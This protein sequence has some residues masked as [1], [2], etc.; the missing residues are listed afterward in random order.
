MHFSQKVGNERTDHAWDPVPG[1]P[2]Y[3]PQPDYELGAPYSFFEY[4]TDNRLHVIMC[5]DQQ[6]IPEDERP[7]PVPKNPN[8]S[9][10]FWRP[11]QDI[12]EEAEMQNPDWTPQNIPYN[13][14]NKKNFYREK[15]DYSDENIKY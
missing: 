13:N 2:P 10:E 5:Q 12:K 4:E 11:Q 8:C 15:Q 3:V 14:Y 1:E 6:T 7:C 9:A